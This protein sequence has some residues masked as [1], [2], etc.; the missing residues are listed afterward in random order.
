MYKCAVSKLAPYWRTVGDYLEYSVVQRNG[1][2]NADN[3]NKKS[4]VA[5]LENWISTNNGR[6]PKTW[7]TFIKVLWE[8]D[9]DLS[10]SVGSEICASLER[11]GVSSNSKLL[12]IVH[13]FIDTY[14]HM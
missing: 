5:V 6:E 4:L 1:F 2:R 3:D 10:I 7:P 14:I 11:E 12:F 8:L 13:S 9:Q